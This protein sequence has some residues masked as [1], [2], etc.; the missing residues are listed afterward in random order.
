M[1]SSFHKMN[2]FLGDFFAF[3]GNAANDRT[4]PI[5]VAV[6]LLSPITVP[7]CR[8]GPNLPNP[9]SPCNQPP[10]NRRK[11]RQA[12]LDANR[13][14]GFE[15]ARVHA[16]SSPR[17]FWSVG[18][19]HQ[20]GLQRASRDARFQ[21]ACVLTAGRQPHC[22]GRACPGGGDEGETKCRACKKN[23]VNPI[24]LGSASPLALQVRMGAG[25]LMRRAAFD[26]PSRQSHGRRIRGSIECRSRSDSP[27]D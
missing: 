10:R 4:C 9:L 24:L 18:Y 3:R 17:N 11:S 2:V 27:I 5:R 14:V 8:P 25:T 1:E 23:P 13:T 20:A 16:L 19:G 15:A 12:K 6:H 26:R 7:D 21:S 22:H